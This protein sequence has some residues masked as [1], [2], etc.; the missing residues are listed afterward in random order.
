MCGG[1]NHVVYGNLRDT[2]RPVQIQP[3]VKSGTQELMASPRIDLSA[4]HLFGN[5]AAEDEDDDVFQAYALHRDEVDAFSDPLRRLCF[6]RAYKGEGKSALLRLASN[7]IR[8]GGQSL[9]IEGPVTAFSPSLDRDEL[10]EWIRGW[11]AALFD[12]IAHAIGEAIG[13]AWTDDAMALVEHA[14]KAGFRSRGLVSA[15]FDRLKPKASLGGAAVQLSSEKLGVSNAEALIQ[16]WASRADSIWIVVDDVDQ[17]FENNTRHRARVAG[18]FVACRHIVNAVPEIR[19]R[20]AVRPNV[21]TTI[22]LHYEPL[23]HIEQ[24][25]TDLRWDV[26]SMRRLLAKRV[27]GYLRRT[28]Q[29]DDYVSELP[30]DTRQR[31]K[32]LIGLVFEDPMDWGSGARS[33]YVILHTLSKHRPRWLIE[34]CTLASS[35]AARANHARVAKSDVMQQL[36]DFGRRR[37]QDTVAEF[38]SQCPDMEELIT[39][40]QGEIEEYATD[41]LITLIERKIRSHMKPQIVGIPG[42]ASSLNIAAFLF[43][44]GVLFA[45]RDNADGSY[46]HIN[47]ADRP[48][49]LRARTNIDSGLRWEVHPVFRQALEMRDSSG[50]EVNKP[51]KTRRIV[52]PRRD[53]R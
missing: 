3:A 41:E 11:K 49:L 5:Q 47:Y 32:E 29:W 23:S 7:R 12:R 45:R 31:D 1:G 27:E 15:I 37:I 33:P 46:E 34:L 28:A 38:R 25:V 13:F 36:D 43:E 20:A 18:F 35:A 51:I 8:S 22:K 48:S 21:W 40:F 4:R 39:A 53:R 6:V 2:G 52:P 9:V 17:N 16:R 19:V 30:T 14:E 24:Y 26:D 50:K 44:I 42:E 10:D